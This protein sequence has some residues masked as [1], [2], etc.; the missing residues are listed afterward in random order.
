MK[1][2]QRLGGGGR[3]A[4]LVKKIKAKG[5]VRSPAA[6]AAKI[7]IAK[8]GQKKMTAMAVAARKKKR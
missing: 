8:Y 5:G 6:V 3:F 1:K 2:S 7:G 4:A